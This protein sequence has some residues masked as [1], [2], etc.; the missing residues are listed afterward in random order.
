MRLRFVAEDRRRRPGHR[1]QACTGQRREG[2]QVAMSGSTDEIQLRHPALGA[3]LPHMTAPAARWFTLP[4]E[5]RDLFGRPQP[6]PDEL[7]QLELSTERLSE[8]QDH[9]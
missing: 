3:S 1:R 8:R 4:G 2:V 5:R 6:F 7:D 9:L